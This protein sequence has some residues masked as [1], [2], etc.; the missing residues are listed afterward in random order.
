[1]LPKRLTML[2]LSAVLVLT[3]VA[4][5]APVATANE[6]HP[7][8]IVQAVIALEDIA[9]S[10]NYYKKANLSVELMK[11]IRHWVD[12]HGTG[13]TGVPL[14][15]TGIT[16]SVCVPKYNDW[17]LETRSLARVGFRYYRGQAT[18][19][20][21]FPSVDRA[22]ARVRQMLVFNR[23]EGRQADA[24]K[25]FLNCIFDEMPLQLRLLLF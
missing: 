17:L 11:D 9:A 1:M 2:M 8:I 19:W 14:I 18:Q 25:A 7:S 23:I 3:T 13:A 22:A 5:T 24:Q 10:G 21:E 12:N 20:Q 15:V 4:F 16:G 6:G